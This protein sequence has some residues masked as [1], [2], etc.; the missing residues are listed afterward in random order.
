MAN[1]MNVFVARKQGAEDLTFYGE[2]SLRQIC[3]NVVNADDPIQSYVGWVEIFGG[4]DGV[5]PVWNAHD[6]LCENGP[7]GTKVVNESKER[8]EYFLSWVKDAQDRGYTITVQT[9][10]L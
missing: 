9:Q 8:I 5:V 7:T 10:A 6:M 4:E 2:C 3:E 1:M